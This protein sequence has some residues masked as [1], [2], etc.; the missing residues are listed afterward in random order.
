MVFSRSPL[1]HCAVQMSDYDKFMEDVKQI[2][3]IDGSVTPLENHYAFIEGL[4]GGAQA[5]VDIY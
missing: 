5:T 4:T 2:C 1:E 3:T